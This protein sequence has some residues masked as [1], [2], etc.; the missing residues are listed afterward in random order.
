MTRISLISLY[1]YSRFFLHRYV[2][3]YRKLSILQIFCLVLQFFIKHLRHITSISLERSDHV[4]WYLPFAQQNGPCYSIFHRGYMCLWNAYKLDCFLLLRC[5]M[6]QEEVQDTIREDGINILLY[7][8]HNNTTWKLFTLYT[9][10]ISPS[11]KPN[12]TS[13]LSFILKFCGLRRWHKS[14]I[15]TP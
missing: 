10:L 15:L 12:C 7:I 4:R 1:I 11:I 9:L 14:F 13:L 3:V 2:Q 5:K 6:R 8:A